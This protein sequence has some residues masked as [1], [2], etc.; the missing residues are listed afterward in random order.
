MLVWMILTAI[1]GTMLA[2]IGLYLGCISLYQLFIGVHGF[3][4]MKPLKKTE[5]KQYTF[6]VIVC[7][8][9]EQEVI[10]GLLDSLQK[11]EYPRDKFD[12]FVIA[13]NCTDQTAQ[14]S[15]D[16]GA[17]VY[18]RFN[19]KEVGKGYALRWALEKI[20][21]DYGDR[22]EAVAVFDADNVADSAFLFHT[23]E[24]LCG[25]ADATQGYRETK[26]AFDNALSGCYAIYWY[27]L[28]RFYH[29]ARSNRGMSCSIGGTGFAFKKAII[30]DKGWDT[31][32][33]TEDSEF[34]ARRTLD[35]RHI[36]FV[37]EAVFFDEQPVEW[38]VAAKQRKRWMCGVMQESRLLRKAAWTSWRGG[39][40][41]AFDILMMQ[42]G[43]PAIGWLLVSMILSL[44][45]SAVVSVWFLNPWPF[46][47]SLASLLVGS[48]LSMFAM[49]ILV[50]AVEKKPLGKF[51]KAI[52]FYPVFMA[53]MM[54]YTFECF[55]KKDMVW[56]QIRH[57]SSS[58]QA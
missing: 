16:H 7:A 55:F 30:A 39:N 6:A 15:R 52:A 47:V 50:L 23:N 11:Q 3:F 41:R 34:A 18:E 57:G 42:Y 8:R 20:A 2:L 49:A 12:L 54:L 45:I 48:Y 9:N 28:S 24:A 36:R 51:V 14:V 44:M 4:N 25:G 37:R 29:K 26:N 21:A 58:E 17:I 5:D 43:F 10:G 33:L 27:T 56:E 40:K 53:A 38:S 35:G 1:L 22:H 19:D 13:D 31:Q 46:I 32:T